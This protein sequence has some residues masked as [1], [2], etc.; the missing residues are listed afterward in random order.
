MMM[1]RLMG[2]WPVAEVA[3]V[4]GRVVDATGIERV[5]LPAGL[6]RLLVNG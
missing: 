6:E 4:A 1:V 3:M 2:E 5:Y